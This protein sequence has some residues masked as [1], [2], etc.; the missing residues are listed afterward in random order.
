[1]TTHVDTLFV[2]RG[3]TFSQSSPQA[4]SSA[5]VRTLWLEPALGALHGGVGGTAR[6][7]CCGH[8]R[9]A[10]SLCGTS[11][12]AA[13]TSSP[14]SPWE[15]VALLVLL[16]AEA[17]PCPLRLGG[18]TL[19]QHAALYATAPVLAGLAGQMAF[20]LFPLLCR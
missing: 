18:L 15:T 3:S 16:A 14:A 8:G 11:P 2:L 6:S 12:V 5:R 17:V 13:R 7:C 4:F 9:L 19:A 10:A 20:A 1:V